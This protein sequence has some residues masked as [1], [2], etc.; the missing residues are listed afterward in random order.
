M[1]KNW[2]RCILDNL[3]QGSYHH[4]IRN[5]HHF[6]HFLLRKP[7]VHRVHTETIQWRAGAGSESGRR[8]SD[9]RRC[10]ARIGDAPI[11][12]LLWSRKNQPARSSCGSIRCL[13]VWSSESLRGMI[14][15][16]FTTVLPI[17]QE[18]KKIT[19]YARCFVLQN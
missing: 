19:L 7:S 12:T 6:P 5:L 11:L 3:F 8:C 15:F 2:L 4:S 16:P 10:N 1:Y 13:W 17:Q 18:Y 14:Q 9:G